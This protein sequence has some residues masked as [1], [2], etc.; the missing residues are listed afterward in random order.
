MK[1]YFTTYGPEHKDQK[2]EYEEL[3]LKAERS[4]CVLSNQKIKDFGVP[5]P[6]IDIRLKKMFKDLN[7]KKRM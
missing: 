2:K 3:D 4:N 6:D 1:N 5:M 7:A